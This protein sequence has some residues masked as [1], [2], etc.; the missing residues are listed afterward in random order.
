MAAPCDG[1]EEGQVQVQQFAAPAHGS[2]AGEP[3]VEAGPPHNLV[4]PI[5]D[6]AERQVCFVRARVVG[7]GR[8]GE[9]N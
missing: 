2:V 9:S 4:E 7:G 5:L 6:P 3:A 1:A 8:Y